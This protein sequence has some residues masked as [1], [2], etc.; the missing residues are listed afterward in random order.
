M[1]CRVWYKHR[2]NLF[3]PT[4]AETASMATVRAINTA[5]ESIIFTNIV[6]WMIGYTATAGVWQFCLLCLAAYTFKLMHVKPSW[7]QPLHRI[8]IYQTTLAAT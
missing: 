6:Y 8:P 5:V 4:Y 2:D 3:L 7:Q 1:A